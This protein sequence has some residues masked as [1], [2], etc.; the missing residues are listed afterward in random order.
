MN[1]I[2][3]RIRRQTGFAYIAA[4][5]LLVVVAGL[6][7]ALLRLTATQQATVNQALLGARASLAARGGVEWA[8]NVL[9][10]QCQP[11]PTS[12]TLTQFQ[13][14]SGFQVTITCSYSTY[15]EGERIRLPGPG[16]DPEQVAD[17]LAKRIYR[18]SAVACNGGGAS[19]PEQGAAAAAA[20]YVER[21]RVAT[22]CVVMD[23]SNTLIPCET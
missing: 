6:A 1:R 17:P 10:T 3:L 22:V 9:G 8:F 16:G 14:E 2:H 11:A 18:I 7:V 21:A 4:V 5:V 23:P 19:C 12:T 20:D 15:F 13:A